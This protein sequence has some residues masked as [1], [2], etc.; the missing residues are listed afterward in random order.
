MAGEV[1]QRGKA[2][3][4]I[5]TSVERSQVKQKQSRETELHGCLYSHVSMEICGM[6]NVETKG[7][8]ETH[9]VAKLVVC[10]E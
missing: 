4:S 1:V 10:S 9:R 6:R 7:S 2:L 8:W 5:L 3:A